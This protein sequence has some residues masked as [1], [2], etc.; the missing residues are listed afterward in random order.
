MKIVTLISKEEC[1]LCDAAKEV[2]ARTRL[3][4][5][6]ELREKKIVPG[7]AEFELYRERIPVILIDGEFAFQF[8]VPERELR[9][10]LLG[11]R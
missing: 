6:F 9:D 7:D 3:D 8:R 2:L 11:A 10:R 4:I 1:H 5:P